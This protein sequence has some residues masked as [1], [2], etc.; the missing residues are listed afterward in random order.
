MSFP[1]MRAMNASKHSSVAA[2]PDFL[3]VASWAH[4][5]WTQ[6]PEFSALA[7]TNGANVTTWPD[8]IGTADLTG[9]TNYP[10][11][12][13]TGLLNSKPAVRWPDTTTERIL[14]NSGGAVH[15]QPYSMVWIMQ[16]T[17][18]SVG[19]RFIETAGLTG[20]RLLVGAVSGNNTLFI[21]CGGG[22]S[23]ISVSPKVWTDKHVLAV[24]FDNASTDIDIDSTDFNPS[25]PIGTGGSSSIA[26]GGEIGNA[27]A[28][29]RFRG[30]IVFFA[31]KSGALTGGEMSALL[32][33]SQSHYGTP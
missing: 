14:R 20:N 26:L 28:N 7:L 18:N 5:Y 30:D 4:A 22:I 17:T 3:A 29:T 24:V 25:T 21:Y 32:A 10:S 12:Q 16:L 27:T 31:T 33:A 6:G 19:A 23:D 9:V 8:E 13:A 2:T 1:A 11:Y 15:T